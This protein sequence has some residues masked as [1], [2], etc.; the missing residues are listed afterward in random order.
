M[1]FLEGITLSE[2]P[3]RERQVIFNL[4]YTWNL[5]KKKK[6]GQNHRNL[7][8]LQ[9]SE[10]RGVGKILQGQTSSSE[11]N[12]FEGSNTQLGGDYR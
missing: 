8:V 9:L 10:S 1:T 2:M 6:K 4:D 5:K 3:T 12:K 7:V 11:M